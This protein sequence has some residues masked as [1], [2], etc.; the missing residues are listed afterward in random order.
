MKKYIFAVLMMCALVGCKDKPTLYVY[1]WADYID[2]EVL[3]EFEQTYNCSVCIDTFDDNETMFA[4]LLAGSSGYDILIPSSYIIPDL[5]K[6][7]LIQ[8]ID[9]S[10]V[11]NVKN[12][13]DEKFNV[14][15][16]QRLTD[17]Y[18]YSVPYAFSMTGILYRKDKVDKDFKFIPSWN[19]LF[20]KSFKGRVCIL[21]DIRE[22][23]GIGLK[24]NG[25]SVNS[26]NEHELAESLKYCK[27][28]KT[29]AS[30][31]D[32][33]Q[34]KSG[35]VNGE[36]NAAIGYNS[37][38]LQ[39]FQ[40]NDMQDILEFFIPDEGAACCFDEMCISV[41]SK[42]NDLAYKFIDFI[43][44]SDVAAKNA[45]YNCTAVPNKAMWQ[46]IP[47]DINNTQLNIPTNI[48]KKLEQI[49]PVGKS[50]PLYNK[51]WD[52]FKSTH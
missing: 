52:K 1:S 34:Y 44:R 27:K 26:T 12:N 11:Q 32:S 38:A 33:I 19:L 47:E 4:K 28:L 51:V 17:D 10:K 42:Q 41:S 20:D 49:K 18:W 48:L 5:V 37:D 35:I 23:I 30:K 31:L 6:N 13:Y 50:L 21:N 29:A 36:F 39:V 14:L 43:Y 3:M 9:L 16:S 7:N 25:Y 8:K 24:M 45:K 40:E 2:P 46:H 15:I 22:I